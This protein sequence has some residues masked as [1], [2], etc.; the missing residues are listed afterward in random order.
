MAKFFG[1]IEIVRIK[2]VYLNEFSS[3]FIERASYISIFIYKTL[4]TFI[5]TLLVIANNIVQTK[6]VDLESF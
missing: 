1:E 5:P 6:L 3:T 2:E 4:D